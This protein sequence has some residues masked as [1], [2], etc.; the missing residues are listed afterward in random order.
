MDINKF[1]EPIGAFNVNIE[2]SNSCCFGEGLSNSHGDGSGWG[3][4]IGYVNSYQNSGNGGGMG[5]GCVN[6]GCVFKP[7]NLYGKHR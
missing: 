2:S 6:V 7:Q 5:K 3:Y 1:I 4:D